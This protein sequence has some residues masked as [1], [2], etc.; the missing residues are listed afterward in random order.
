MLRKEVAQC[1]HVP[2]DRVDDER[3][4]AQ[5]RCRVT[6]NQQGGARDERQA[7]QS[8]RPTCPRT[9]HC[10]GNDRKK[11][12]ADDDLPANIVQA[13]A[14][15]ASD[16]GGNVRLHG[17]SGERAHQDD[18]A[19]RNAEANRCYAQT[20]TPRNERQPR[21]RY[22]P[23]RKPAANQEARIGSRIFGDRAVN[24]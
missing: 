15:R 8:A 2:R 9:A 17:L 10:P 5:S 6:S 24:R 12:P 14:K 3:S 13:A 20:V 16:A 11:H 21:K 4:L 23:G 18:T 7:E 22:R 19:R 1:Q